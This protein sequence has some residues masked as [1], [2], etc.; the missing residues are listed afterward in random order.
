MTDAAIANAQKRRDE[1]AARI[2]QLSQEVE[3]LR[4][5]IAG[6]DQF[7]ATW[8]LYAS[9]SAPAVGHTG[10]P[11]HSQRGALPI[12]PPPPPVSAIP[13]P[14]NPSRDDVG[15]AAW[16]LMGTLGRPIPR[17]ELFALLAKEGIHIYG[18]DPEMVLSTMMWRMQEHF[19]RIPKFGYWKKNEPYPSA[20]YVPGA[21]VE[22]DGE[23]AKVIQNSIFDPA[24]VQDA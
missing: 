15:R 22:D 6:V 16:G 23:D 5:E 7:I 18:K 21:N 24:S 8:H 11:H 2:N 20:G 9:N 19:V 12:P 1:I 13:S 14:K 4:R 17:T 3:T 10:S